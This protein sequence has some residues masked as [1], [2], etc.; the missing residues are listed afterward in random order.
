VGGGQAVVPHDVGGGQAVV[1]RDGVSGQAAV[2]RD[3]GEV[4]HPLRL[5]S[6]RNLRPMNLEV[7]SPHHSPWTVNSRTVVFGAAGA[8]LYGVLGLFSFLIPGTQ[9][10]ALRPAFAIVPF[11]G[12]RFGVVAGFLVGFV[13][14]VVIDFF[15]GGGQYWNWSVANGLVGALAALI[16]VAIPPISNETVRTL[17]TALGALAATAIGLLFVVTDMW[18]GENVDFD[19]FLNRN[20]LPAL[21]TNGIAV[22]VIVPVLDVLWRPFSTWARL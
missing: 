19:A 12:K 17:V 9:S 15:R 16:F 22:V 10:V 20:Y 11:F 8:A 5:L 1:P 21:L 7:L 6:E 18:I 13:G 14:N 2:P 4:P 3:V